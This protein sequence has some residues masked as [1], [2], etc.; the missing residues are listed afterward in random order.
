MIVEYKY[1][2]DHDRN[3]DRLKNELL[4]SK[5]ILD[6]GANIN[7]FYETDF[8]INKVRS[9]TVDLFDIPESKLHFKGNISLASV[10]MNI[11]SYVQKNGKFDY[12]YISHTLEDISNPKLVCNMMGMVAKKGFI[13]VP[14]K[15]TECKR[16]NE[17]YRGYIHHRWIYNIENKVLKGYPKQNFLEYEN[18]L[19]EIANKHNKNNAEL[20]IFWED[21]V[22]LKIVNDDFLGPSVDAVIGY[23]KNLHIN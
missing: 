12:C 23:Y 14:S 5:S 2:S 15:Y 13:A 1:T 20:Q 22:D 16:H 7:S 11:L 17:K 6:I 10:W 8:L 21:D 3:T 9:A 4:N 18:H 19:D